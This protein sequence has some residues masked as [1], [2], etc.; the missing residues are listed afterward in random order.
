MRALVL[1]LATA[2]ALGF[3]A[4]L[5]QAQNSGMSGSTGASQGG[6]AS[7]NSQGGNMG[8]QDRGGGKASKSAGSRSERGG[9]AAGSRS[10]S[11][12][13]TVGASQ[14]SSRTTT[15]GRTHVGI[16]SGGR[17]DVVIHRRHGRHVVA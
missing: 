14:E 13:N 11:S 7:Q 2:A 9:Q 12:R 17:D 16:R 4:Q 5:A 8:S 10:E 1:T 6:S 3:A 15:R